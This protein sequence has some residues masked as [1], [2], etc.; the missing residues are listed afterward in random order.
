MF[1]QAFIHLTTEALVIATALTLALPFFL[2]VVAV[3]FE[4]TT[5]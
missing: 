2:A 1:V 4:M 3:Y 5:A